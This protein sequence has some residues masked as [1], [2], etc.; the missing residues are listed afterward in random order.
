MTEQQKFRLR[1]H[2]WDPGTS[3]FQFLG[4]PGREFTRSELESLLDIHRQSKSNRWKI[5]VQT[6]D[7][8]GQWFTVELHEIPISS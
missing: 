5:E 2:Q 7:G 4:A 6:Q 8:S 3:D 1:Y